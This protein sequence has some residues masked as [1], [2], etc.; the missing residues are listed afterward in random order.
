VFVVD[1]FTRKKLF[2]PETAA[3]PRLCEE[4][5]FLRGGIHWSLV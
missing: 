1:A 3:S 2:R 5:E 4:N